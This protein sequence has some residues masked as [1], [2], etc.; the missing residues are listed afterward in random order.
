MEARYCYLQL[1]SNFCL[2]NV[3]ISSLL[4]LIPIIIPLCHSINNIFAD[5]II[6]ISINVMEAFCSLYLWTSLQLRTQ[7]TAPSF[8]GLCDPSTLWFSPLCSP[9]SVFF[10]Q[11]F[12]IYMSHKCSC[13]SGFSLGSLFNTVPK[14]SNQCPSFLYHV[15][16]IHKSLSPVDVFL[17]SH[18]PVPVNC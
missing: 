16:A 4:P 13:T 3:I 8:Q 15:Y 11:F 6:S 2:L 10:N 5:I 12:F 18:K 9:S 1:S 17:L 7:W 14:Q